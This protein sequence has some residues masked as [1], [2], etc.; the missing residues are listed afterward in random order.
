MDRTVNRNKFIAGFV[1]EFGIEEQL[2]RGLP[3]RASTRTMIRKA[4]EAIQERAQMINFATY[5]K[6]IPGGGK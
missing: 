5:G 1:G 3:R 6:V 4:C 2:E